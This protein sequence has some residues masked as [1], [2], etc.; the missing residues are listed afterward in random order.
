MKSDV[1]LL[2][3]EDFDNPLATSELFSIGWNSNEI[4]KSLQ[5]G[6]LGLKAV[7]ESE[8]VGYCL[9]RELSDV[10][11]ILDLAVSFKWRSK[12]FAQQLLKRLFELCESKNTSS[13]CLEVRESNREAISL[14]TCLGFNHNATRKDYYLFKSGDL[15]ERL[16]EDAL[17]FQK[18][19]SSL[20]P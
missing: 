11:E 20:S 8:I 12:G 10:V 4:L 9:F 7:V 16:R 19:L 6:S 13:I 2:R 5:H 3:P 1:S 14:Y 18:T 15:N 17:I